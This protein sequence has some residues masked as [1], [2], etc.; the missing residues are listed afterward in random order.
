LREEAE[1]AM[2]ATLRAQVKSFA[3]LSTAIKVPLPKLALVDPY[4]NASLR[5]VRTK[6]RFDIHKIVPSNSGQFVNDQRL[7]VKVN[8]DFQQRIKRMEK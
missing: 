5:K 2:A 7:L 6:G 4:F 1:K 3:Q 8:P